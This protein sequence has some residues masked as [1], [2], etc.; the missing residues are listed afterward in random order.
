MFWTDWQ[1]PPRIMRAGMD[2]QGQTTLI[3]LNLTYPNGLTIDYKGAT[4]IFWI[5]P[6]TEDPGSIESCKLDGSD[7][8][9]WVGMGRFRSFKR[10]YNI[11]ILVKKIKT[12]E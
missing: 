3:S 5:D 6:G 12:H 7:R 1:K 4:R 9:V 11:M 8:K 2:G 10:V